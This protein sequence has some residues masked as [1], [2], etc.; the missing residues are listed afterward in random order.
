MSSAVTL[1]Y[2]TLTTVDRGLQKEYVETLAF[3]PVSDQAFLDMVRP[4]ED[5]TQTPFGRGRKVTV[6]TPTQA[7]SNVFQVESDMHP[8]ILVLTQAISSIADPSESLVTL[9]QFLSKFK[10]IDGDIIPWERLS[11]VSIVNDALHDDE[12]FRDVVN[13]LPHIQIYA[14]SES[15][16]IV[17]K[18]TLRFDPEPISDDPLARR[19]FQRATGWR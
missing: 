12:E 17:V 19:S 9:T 16:N 14:Q 2:H 11:N 10:T 7:L 8:N 15:E 1:A 13:S 6:S 18:T 5:I 4:E 3:Q